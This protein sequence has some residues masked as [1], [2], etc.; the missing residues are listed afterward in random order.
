MYYITSEIIFMKSL[1]TFEFS[2]FLKKKK[3]FLLMQT[4]ENYAFIQF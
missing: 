4:V 3:Y 1:L 2:T